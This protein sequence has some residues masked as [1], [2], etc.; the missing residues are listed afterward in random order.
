MLRLSLLLNSVLLVAVAILYYLHFNQPE[1]QQ[2]LT[3]ASVPVEPGGIY[4]VNSDSLLDNYTF[5]KE[6]KS[7]L[8]KRQERIRTELKSAGQKLEADVQQYQQTAAGMTDD[9]R[10]KTEES[11]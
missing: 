2:P 5:Y 6:R 3:A 10:Q 7:D 1:Q 11:L 9:Q 4:F 8:E